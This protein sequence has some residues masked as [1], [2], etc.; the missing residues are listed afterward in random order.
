MLLPTRWRRTQVGEEEMEQ[1]VR[2]ANECETAA[3]VEE[4]RCKA[5]MTAEVFIAV[6]LQGASGWRF[7]S[8]A[9]V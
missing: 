9:E 2:A 1:I 3:R 6:A 4:Q 7:G 5:G 8:T